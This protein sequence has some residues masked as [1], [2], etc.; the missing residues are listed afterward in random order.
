MNAH[1]RVVTHRRPQLLAVAHDLADFL[2]TQRV[3]AAQ[4]EP[5]LDDRHAARDRRARDIGTARA[6]GD[7]DDRTRMTAQRR[8]ALELDIDHRLHER[9]AALAV[10]V[11]GRDHLGELDLAR[12]ADLHDER[13]ARARGARDEIEIRPVEHQI[14]RR[15]AH[16]VEARDLILVEHGREHHQIPALG[17]LEQLRR[18]ARRHARELDRIDLAVGRDV[19]GSQRTLERAELPAIERSNDERRMRRPDRPSKVDHPH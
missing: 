6:I 16:P 15:R 14:E 11:R 2:R 3:V 1:W 5:L 8:E 10:R 12:G 9:D 18:P 19:D 4:H 17:A 7:A 13:L